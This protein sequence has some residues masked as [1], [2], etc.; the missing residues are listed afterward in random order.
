MHDCMKTITLT[1]DAY[2]RLIA[3]K[4]PAGD[5]FSK[6]VLRVVPRKGTLG[7]V[8]EAAGQL[9]PLTSRQLKVMEETSA[10]G[11]DPARHRGAWTT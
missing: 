9:P 3:W 11:R 7:Q 8:V 2:E 6:V 5:S 10:W 4:R 1:D